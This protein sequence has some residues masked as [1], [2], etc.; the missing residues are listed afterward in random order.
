M[1]DN[2]AFIMKRLTEKFEKM[3]YIASCDIYLS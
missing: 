2:Y 3:N 1:T